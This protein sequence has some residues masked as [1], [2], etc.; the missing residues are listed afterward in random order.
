M[1]RLTE[2]ILGYP[3]RRSLELAIESFH[4][5]SFPVGAVVTSSSGAVVSEGRNRRGDICAPFGKMFDTTIA[6]AEIDALAAL[7]IGD[8]ETF[9]LHSSLEPCL[10]CRAAALMIGVGGIHYLGADVLASGLD[11]AES[12]N[13]FTRQRYPEVVGPESGRAALLASAL[14]LSVILQAKPDSWMAEQ[15]RSRSPRAAL[16]AELMISE[17]AWP[18]PNEDLDS[19][20]KRFDRLLNRK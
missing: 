15:Y 8:Y 19:T 20:L 5:G 18:S 12:L 6:H 13:E 17:A 1:S 9:T 10:M 4:S 16:A 14:P 3:L 2:D 11:A 7:P